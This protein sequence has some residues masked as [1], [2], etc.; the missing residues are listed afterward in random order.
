MMLNLTIARQMIG[1]ELLRLRKKRGFIALVLLVVIAPV[2]IV[3]GYNVIEH[4]S[5]PATHGPAEAC[6]VTPTYSRCSACSWGR[7]RR[8]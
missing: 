4:A 5:D 1:G 2:V 3:F 8:F 7:S 6:T